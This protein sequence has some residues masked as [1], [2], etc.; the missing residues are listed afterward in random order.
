[1]RFKFTISKGS[2]SNLESINFNLQYITTTS[3]CGVTATLLSLR[4]D[5]L[6]RFLLLPVLST[7]MSA[8]VKHSKNHCNQVKKQFRDFVKELRLVKSLFILK[9]VQF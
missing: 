6:V 1:M 3:D 7:H 4:Q 2:F 9:L 8:V 5:S